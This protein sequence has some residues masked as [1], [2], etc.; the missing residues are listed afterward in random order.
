MICAVLSTTAGSPST[1]AV[2]SL[3]QGLG[4]LK[5][6]SMWFSRFRSNSILGNSG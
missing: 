1:M 6:T 4:G 5:E 2:R 3:P